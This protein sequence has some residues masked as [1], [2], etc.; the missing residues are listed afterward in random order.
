M[1]ISTF[2]YL[3]ATTLV[4][5]RSTRH[6]GKKDYTNPATKLQSRQLSPQPYPDDSLHQK[7]KRQS[8]YL[9]PV[10]QSNRS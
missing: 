6:V 1:R 9:N 7:Q 8:S 3:F 4:A 5:A 10:S 2:L